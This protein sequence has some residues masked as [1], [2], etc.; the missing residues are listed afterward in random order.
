LDFWGEPKT[1]PRNSEDAQ[2]EKK[3]QGKRK[4]KDKGK[5]K[6]SKGSEEYSKK[7]DTTKEKKLISCWISTKNHYAKKCPLK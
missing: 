1:G 2:G 5:M 7:T 4:R 6:K 3:Q